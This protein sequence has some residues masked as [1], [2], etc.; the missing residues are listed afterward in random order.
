MKILAI[1]LAVLLTAC[2]ASPITGAGYLS[3]GT[4][5]THFASFT[6]WNNDYA[7]TVAHYE[8]AL[9]DEKKSSTLD[10]KFFKQNGVARQ[11]ANPKDNEIVYMTG[12]TQAGS[13]YKLISGRVVPDKIYGYD[14]YRLIEGL[15]MPGMSGG[16]VVNKQ[17]QVIGINVGYSNQKIKIG[18]KEAFYTLFLPYEEI[19]KEFDS[20]KKLL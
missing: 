11:W 16:P 19:S 18:G 2:T 7:A 1:A 12:Y 6:Q 4:L 8:E 20:I 9:R 14:R 5:V 10:I 17:G 3:S 13:E 15:N